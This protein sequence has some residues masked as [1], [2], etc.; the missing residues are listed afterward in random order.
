MK[1]L[2]VFLGDDVAIQAARHVCTIFPSIR[3]FVRMKPSQPVS[4][5]IPGT[6]YS[7]LFRRPPQQHLVL[8]KTFRLDANKENG[9]VSQRS[10]SIAHGVST[11]FS[12]E[13]YSL[14]WPMY[15]SSKMSVLVEEIVYV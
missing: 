6:W 12:K 9:W 11:T 15:R 13:L 10:T 1:Y 7:H 3:S 5:N 2:I 8:T 14:I 4:C